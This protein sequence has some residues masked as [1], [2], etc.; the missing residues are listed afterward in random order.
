M[1]ILI[2]IDGAYLS[3]SSSDRSPFIAA[4]GSNGMDALFQNGI[5]VPI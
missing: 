1:K 3:C 2:A 5:K 4:S